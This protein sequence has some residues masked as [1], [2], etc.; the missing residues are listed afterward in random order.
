MPILP[1]LFIL[2]VLAAL[3]V[4]WYTFRVAQEQQALEREIQAFQAGK[5]IE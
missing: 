2:C 1:L 5:A 3:V 4:F